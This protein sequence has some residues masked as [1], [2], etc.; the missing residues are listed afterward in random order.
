[1]YCP[2]SDDA[3]IV[4]EALIDTG[5]SI[6]LVTKDWGGLEFNYTLVPG[7]TVVWP[8]IPSRNISLCTHVF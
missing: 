4:V 2:I 3:A 6:T 8:N 5:S 7:E 1:M